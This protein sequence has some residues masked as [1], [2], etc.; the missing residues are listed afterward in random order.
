LAFETGWSLLRLG[1]WKEAVTELESYEKGR[2]G[3]GLTSES[4][5]RA[6]LALGE[7]DKAEA[8]L[9]EALERDPNLKRTVLFDLAAVERR[10]KQEKP[11]RIALSTG[12]GHN[13]N[14]IQLGD[15][16]PQPRDVSKK[17]SGFGRF[18]LGGSY[19]LRPTREDTLTLGYGLETDLYSRI[20]KFNLFESVGLA[21]YRHV[22]SRD[23]A[24]EIRMSD[25]FT[26]LHG[27]NFS[28][29][30]ALRPALTY[31]LTDWSAAE[32]GYTA[33]VDKYYFS[34][35]RATGVRTRDRDALSH[36][37]SLTPYFRVPGT[38]LSGRIGYFHV[39]NQ[40]D[41]SD[42]D[43]K[44]N[45][46]VAGLSHPLF[47]QIS[48]DVSYVRTFDRYDSRRNS[49]SLLFF[50]S[51]FPRKDDVDYVTVQLVRPIYDWLSAY[52]RFEHTNNQSN[53]QGFNYKQRII[54]I[55]FV[56]QF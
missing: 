30:W 24:G 3:R 26:Q 46:L 9:K 48:G 55:G 32:L 22:F 33:A 18:T 44:S 51:A 25:R 38:Q 42:W 14:V 36:T 43:F 12:G 8:K 7:L 35:V 28:N 50:P 49:Y 41:G 56:A 45:G 4:L 29:Q 19:D 11:W 16:R 54:N 37:L 6:Y 40:A 47:W 5:G 17:S 39:W 31:R 2:P 27:Q 34:A 15:G 20:P 53:I 21:N 13:S 10:R 23:L 52:A 1:R